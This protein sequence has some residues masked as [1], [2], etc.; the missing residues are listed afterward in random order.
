MRDRGRA[1]RRNNFSTGLCEKEAES[2]RDVCCRESIQSSLTAQEQ[3][4]YHDGVPDVGKPTRTAL[5]LFFW[6]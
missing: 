2:G 4:A 3:K 5:Q 6:S 1:L